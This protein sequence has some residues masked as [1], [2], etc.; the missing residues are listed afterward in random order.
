MARQGRAG[1]GR[2]GIVQLELEM[3][4]LCLLCVHGVCPTPGH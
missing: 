4:C 3:F 1:Q 2:V